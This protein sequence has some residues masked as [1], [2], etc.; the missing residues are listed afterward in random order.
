MPGM[1]VAGGLERSGLPFGN[2]ELTQVNKQWDKGPRPLGF[3]HV[4]S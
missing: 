1:E 3:P 4:P 2:L